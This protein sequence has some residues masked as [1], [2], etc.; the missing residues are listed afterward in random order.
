MKQVDGVME[1]ER[2]CSWEATMWPTKI[3]NPLLNL[4]KHIKSRG[5]S[6]Q[7]IG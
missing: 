1:R 7:L 5:R 3:S 4:V 6:S 2:D